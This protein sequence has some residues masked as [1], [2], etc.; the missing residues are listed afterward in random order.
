MTKYLRDIPIQKRKKVRASF[1]KIIENRKEQINLLNKSLINPL[2]YDTKL[3]KSFLKNEVEIE[4]VLHHLD[5]TKKQ[6]KGM[7][8]VKI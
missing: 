1:L 2:K 3:I 4:R 5:K 7:L 8:K 6:I